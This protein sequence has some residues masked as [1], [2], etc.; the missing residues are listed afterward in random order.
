MAKTKNKESV[1]D[2]LGINSTPK[3]T[4]ADKVADMQLL[5]EV[6]SDFDK[7]R[8]YV[9]NNYQAVW[10][11]CFKAY[12]GIRTRRGYS[13]VADDF[14][15]ETFSIVE[16]LKASI[17]GT[18]PKFKYMPLTEEQKQDTTTL[19]ALVDFYWSQNNMTEKLLNWVGDMIVY[20]NGIFKTR[21]N[22][23]GFKS[24]INR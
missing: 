18:K 19:N 2:K 22:T 9:K 8:N 6:M 11:D 23:I 16:S 7:A 1:R 13:G 21:T 15:P 12:N 10:E 17:A 5:T 24:N 3:L 14:V 20:G 4:D